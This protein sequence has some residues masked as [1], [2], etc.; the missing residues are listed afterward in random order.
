[1]PT[2]ESIADLLASPFDLELPSEYTSLWDI[3]TSTM[4]FH[5]NEHD[6]DSR[7]VHSVYPSLLDCVLRSLVS[8]CSV[9][10]TL[11]AIYIPAIS[12]YTSGFFDEEALSE[13]EE[14]VIK[15]AQSL[16]VQ[17]LSISLIMDSFIHN[18]QKIGKLLDRFKEPTIFFSP[19]LDIMLRKC[20]SWQERCHILAQGLI[21]CCKEL[22]HMLPRFV[23]TKDVKQKSDNCEFLWASQVD[24]SMGEASELVEDDIT[25]GNN[26]SILNDIAST[27]DLRTIHSHHAHGFRITGSPMKSPLVVVVSDDRVISF[28]RFFL[29]EREHSV[30]PIPLLPNS[31][32]IAHFPFSVSLYGKKYCELYPNTGAGSDL[33]PSTTPFLL[34]RPLLS[35]SSPSL[36]MLQTLTSNP[37]PL[38][39]TS[40]CF[41]VPEKDLGSPFSLLVPR[42]FPTISVRSEKKSDKGISV[43]FPPSYYKE[44]DRFA[45]AARAAEAEAFKLAR[46]IKDETAK[47]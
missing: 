22:A 44:T 38:S 36:S 35:F 8:P 34:P 21:V 10:T 39:P 23:D 27:E 32:W 5:M 20:T 15:A 25:G 18:A 11:R 33:A 12:N 7:I 41:A 9:Y 4:T 42:R 47:Q 16:R 45:R 30:V 14:K 37:R 46:F 17:P 2:F 40:P 13:F 1:M 3:R 43:P 24:D 31:D 6:A 29:E 19:I 26:F 28:L